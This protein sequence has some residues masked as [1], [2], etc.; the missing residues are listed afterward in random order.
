MLKWLA[1]LFALLVLTIIILADLGKLGFIKFLSTLYVD[2]AGHFL[3]YG[4]LAL[5]AELAILQVYPNE[6]RKRLIQLTGWAL[7]VFIT[8]E[9][10]SQ[11]YFS[12]RTFDLIDLLFSYLGVLFF[13]W[14]VWKRS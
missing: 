8:I 11:L 10:I 4:I 2:K 12:N 3:L 1:T 7:A 14:I 9:E 5:L 13:S 6:N